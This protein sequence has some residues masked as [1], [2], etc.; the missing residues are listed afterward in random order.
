MCKINEQMFDHILTC[1]Y[2]VA[3]HRFKDKNAFGFGKEFLGIRFRIRDMN[4]VKIG[5]VVGV[6]VIGFSAF[7]LYTVDIPAP[8]NKVERTLPDDQFPR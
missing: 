3:K 2:C 8:E 4:K 5:I 1:G 7:F 6:V